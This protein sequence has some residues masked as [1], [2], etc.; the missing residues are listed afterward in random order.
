MRIAFFA[1]MGS[2]GGRIDRGPCRPRSSTGVTRMSISLER[3]RAL[4]K[5]AG[6][7]SVD[8]PRAP[9]PGARPA[10]N[11]VAAGTPASTTAPARAATPAGRATLLRKPPRDTDAAPLP[12]APRTPLPARS[13]DTAIAV[14]PPIAI[15]PFDRR[16][17][18]VASL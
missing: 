12:P 7:P 8:A 10:G 2:A 1:G 15:E 4:R 11:A 3:L 17:A 6:D 9:A 18:D 13:G 16:G 5:Q 14:A